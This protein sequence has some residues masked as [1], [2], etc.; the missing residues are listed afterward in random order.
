MNQGLLP[1]D[2]QGFLPRTVAR[3]GRFCHF[4]ICGPSLNYHHAEALGTPG[5][6]VPVSPCWTPSGLHMERRIGSPSWRGDIALGIP[7]IL[8]HFEQPKRHPFGTPIS[9]PR[10][11]NWRPHIS[12]PMKKKNGPREGQPQPGGGRARVTD[13]A[14]KGEGEAHRNAPG[15]PARPTRPRRTSTCTHARDPGVSSSDP[16]GEVSASTRNSPC[17]SAESPVERRTVRENGRVSLRRL[18]LHGQNYTKCTQFGPCKKIVFHRLSFL[19][20]EY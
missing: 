2:S 4:G 16:Q 19:K 9:T 3:E 6:Q 17:A 14:A 15:R 8:A 20:T 1:Q 11:V 18:K 10:V 7:S 5:G 13:T 12:V